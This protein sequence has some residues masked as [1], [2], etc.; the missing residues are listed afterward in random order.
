[1]HYLHKPFQVKLNT[2]PVCLPVMRWFS[3]C[4]NFMWYVVIESFGFDF[5][6]V[7]SN[8]TFEKFCHKNKKHF[9]NLHIS[10]LGDAN[11]QS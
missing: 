3:I 5:E 1:M 10:I 8:D 9:I 2:V 4:V 7:V 11:F 6:I